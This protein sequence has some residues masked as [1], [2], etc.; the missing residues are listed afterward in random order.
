MIREKISCTVEILTRNNAQTLRRCLESVRDFAEIIVI[1][2]NSTDRTREIAASHG[3]V[4][5]KQY[6]TNEP[7]VRI[8][9]F[10]EVRNKGLA[11]ATYDWF[12]FIDADEYL[13]PEV[14]EEIRL[15]VESSNPP[16][17][18]FWQPRKYVFDDRVVECATTYPNRQIRLFHRKFVSK[19]IKPIHE[20]IEIKGGTVVGVL[21]NDE[22]V[23]L[24]SLEKLEER[25]RRYMIMEVERLGKVGLQ[26]LLRILFR[27]LL[28][29]ALYAFRYIRN[30]FSCRGFRL[31]FQYEW[32]RHKYILMFMARV[33]KS[34]VG[35]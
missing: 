33:L 21:R 7:L 18:I 29:F 27:Q 3:C 6:E 30:T 23:P 28:L 35:I 2:G 34:Y 11:H 10:S 25:W 16:A 1:D 4:I 19:F 8:S 17:H 20:R 12:M 14:V 15:I 26:T 32:G 9:D 13:S 31:P 24:E 5:L 22:Y